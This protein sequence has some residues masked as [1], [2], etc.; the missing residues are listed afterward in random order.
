MYLNTSTSDVFE[1]TN[2]EWTLICNIKGLK[3]DTGVSVVDTEIDENGDLIVTFSND[4][5]V[6]AGH[7]KDVT[8]YTVSFY[9]G[10]DLV[11]TRTVEPNS[12]IS[13][14]SAQETA[15]YTI[16]SW[17]VEGYDERPWVFSGYYADRVTENVK[18]CADFTAKEYQINFIDSKFGKNLE[19]LPVTYNASYN[20]TQFLEETGYTF[21]NW[22]DSNK[23]IFPLTGTYRF[24]RDITLYANWDA[25][26][27]TVTLVPGY[28]GGETTTQ[29][30]VF[31][32]NYSLPSLYRNHYVF[33]GWY[34]GNTRISNNAIWKIDHDITLTGKWNGNAN[35]Y[36]FDAGNGNVDPITKTIEFGAPYELPIPS[37]EYPY[38]FDYW[39]LDG[40]PIENSGDSWLYESSE[41]TMVAHYKYSDEYLS[42]FEFTEVDGGYSVSNKSC[43]GDIVIPSN[44]N[45]LPVISIQ[46]YAF[47]T[48]S[49]LTSITI[50]NSVTSIGYS[51][52]SD[53]YSLTS[54][55]IPNS[56]TSIESNAFYNCIS[57]TSITIP[58]SVTSIGSYA[59]RGCSSLTSITI[60]NSVT[61]IESNAF[62]NC[63][64]LTSITIPNSVTSIG[65]YAFR[66]CSSL[67]SIT[68]DDGNTIYDSRNNCNALIETS[69][70]TLI[71]GCS[72]TIIPNSVTSIESYAFYNCSSLTSITIP[73]SVTSIGYGAFSV[74]SSLTSITIPNS[75]TSIG[76]S[77]FSYCSSLTSISIPNSVTSIAYSAFSDCSSLTSIT[78]PNSVTS[79][80]LEAFGGC[81]SLTSITIPKSVDVMG[82]SVFYRC[83]SSLTI[84]CAA[85]SKPAPWEDNW[86]GCSCTI[87]WGF[88]DE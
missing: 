42:M 62:Y 14:P 3:G 18:L 69:T 51:A 2:G 13:E 43:E 73:N 48:C 59:F 36:V 84:K 78:I 45:G 70:N 24:A 64:S 60:P 1:K 76:Y 57:L 61:S 47:Y 11:A 85:K 32:S 28:E 77:A 86:C 46:D 9:C 72:S 56:V 66:G 83:S 88:I 22:N 49:L 19:P 82:R 67:T 31:D 4:Q 52:F 74:C 12:K 35:T 23:E 44:F 30:V 55:T 17:H 63:I 54:I 38:T 39:E 37:I 58:N 33:L 21:C 5:V 10:D 79:I 7:V 41:R 81:S 87:V 15:G 80:E 6:N 40:Q 68:V 34:D 26:T 53:C 20:I 25:N 8:K 50:P 65:S 16:S 71:C 29:E 27:Y 75:V